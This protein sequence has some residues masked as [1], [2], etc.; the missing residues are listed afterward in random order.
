MI[1]RFEPRY[2]QLLDEGY[3]FKTVDVHQASDLR[4]RY[5]ALVRCY[6]DFLGMTPI[7]FDD[8]ERIMGQYL[9]VFEA[10]FVNLVYDPH[11][12]IGGFSVAYPDY[13]D[14]IRLCT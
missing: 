8:F 4:Q 2:Q 3:Q 13:S 5:N 7:D 11:G 14:A 6:Q 10:R 12:N 1:T 9:R